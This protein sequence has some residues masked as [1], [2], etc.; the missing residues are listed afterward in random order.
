MLV[1]EIIKR[2]VN[3]TGNFE[4]Y[5]AINKNAFTDGQQQEINL[6]VDCVNLTNSNI[7]T[8]YVRLY[9]SVEVNNV[10]GEILY[11]KI[12]NKTIYEIICVKNSNGVKVGFSLTGSGIKTENGK[13]VVTYTYFPDNV[14]YEDAINEYQLKINERNFVY[15]VISEYLYVKGVFDEAQIWEDKF[16]IE[17]RSLLRSQRNISLKQRRWC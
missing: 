10:G 16:K 1:K 3:Y 9:G 2:V 12:T 5:D 14:Q 13:V 8:N 15:G 11:S 6:L 4:L 17:M 7:A